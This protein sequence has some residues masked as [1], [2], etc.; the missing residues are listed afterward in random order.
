MQAYNQN[1]S[2]KPEPKESIQW[3]RFE[4]TDING[5]N[6]THSAVKT[7]HSTTTVRKP[8]FLKFLDL[9]FNPDCLRSGSNPAIPL[10]LI[11]GY[12]NGVQIWVVLVSWQ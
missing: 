2:P 5:E 3:L 4:K 6:L 1:N 11:L 12:T 7:L 9:S 8:V 10:L